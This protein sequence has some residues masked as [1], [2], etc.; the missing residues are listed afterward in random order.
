MEARRAIRNVARPNNMELT[1][2]ALKRGDDALDLRAV[3]DEVEDC[4][5]GGAG[6]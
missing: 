2:G 6:C 3:R 1:V 5:D 4:T